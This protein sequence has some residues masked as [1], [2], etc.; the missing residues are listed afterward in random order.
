MSISRPV[1]S[2]EGRT[3][4]TPAMLFPTEAK[5]A[6]SARMSS[7]KSISRG[8]DT[9]KSFRTGEN[10]ILAPSSAAA[11]PQAAVSPAS[12]ETHSVRSQSISDV[13]KKKSIIRMCNRSSYSGSCSQGPRA[14][15]WQHSRCR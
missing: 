4:L 14:A 10:V 3:S 9:E 6:R 11:A 7:E 5:Q 8:H 1:F 12:A 2:S 13:Q 15:S